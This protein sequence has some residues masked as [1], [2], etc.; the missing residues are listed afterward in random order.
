MSKQSVP[1]KALVTVVA[2][3]AGF[4]WGAASFAASLAVVMDNGQVV[5][6]AT[7]ASCRH[8]EMY[9]YELQE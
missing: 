8:R 9:E 6:A 2:A 3:S 4:H 5:H 1:V 7:C